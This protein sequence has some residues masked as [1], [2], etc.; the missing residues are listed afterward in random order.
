MMATKPPKSLREMA[1]DTA[2]AEGKRGIRCPECGCCDTRVQ[3]TRRGDGMVVRYRVCRH[4]G[5]HRTTVES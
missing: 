3:T 5:N 2:R 1:E 4:C